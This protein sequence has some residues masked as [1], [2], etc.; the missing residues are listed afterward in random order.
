VLHS[1][2][3]DPTQRHAVSAG[4]QGA[5]GGVADL[6][7]TRALP[8]KKQSPLSPKAAGRA[9]QIGVGMEGSDRS[10]L[11][12]LPKHSF[13]VGNVFS[14]THLRASQNPLKGQPEL[15]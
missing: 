7:R 13:F 3:A 5:T 9:L 2:K 11:Q 14:R 12:F 1:N 10:L 4:G 8:V 15:T 6:L